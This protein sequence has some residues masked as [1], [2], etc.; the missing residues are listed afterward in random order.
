MPGGWPG[1]SDLAE[2]KVLAGQP[3]EAFVS[4]VAAS[5]LTAPAELTPPQVNDRLAVL[6][7]SRRLCGTI[8]RERS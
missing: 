6:V 2:R 3:T 8:G 5:S 4:P 1:V 7:P